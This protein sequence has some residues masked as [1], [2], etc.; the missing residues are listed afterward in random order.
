MKNVIQI[1]LMFDGE[2]KECPEKMEEVIKILEEN[3]EM[4]RIQIGEISSLPFLPQSFFI[5]NKKN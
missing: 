5:K 4:E 3:Y 1:N 2:I